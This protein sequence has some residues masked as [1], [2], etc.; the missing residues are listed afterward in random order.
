MPRKWAS[1]WARRCS[2]DIGRA[3]R[4]RG[5]AARRKLRAMRD[6]AS[7]RRPAWYVI[8]LRPLGQHDAVRRAAAR[9]GMGCVALSTMRIVVRDDAQARRRLREALAAP[10]VVFTSPNAV[11]AAA[12]TTTLRRKRSQ[13]MFAIG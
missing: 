1:R 12:A 7:P 11:R 5:G 3:L 13:R 6:D 2:L 10:R 8:S 9:A 4:L